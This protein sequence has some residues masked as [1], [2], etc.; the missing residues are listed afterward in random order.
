MLH[1]G[2]DAAK[3][4]PP[5]DD[6]AVDD[7]LLK[8]R[9]SDLAIKRPTTDALHECSDKLLIVDRDGFAMFKK[10]SGFDWNYLVYIRIKSQPLS[11]TLNQL[12]NNIVTT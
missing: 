3:L 4:G 6:L 7:D 9:T 2:R 10:S 12:Q 1:S 11:N 8:R 5:F